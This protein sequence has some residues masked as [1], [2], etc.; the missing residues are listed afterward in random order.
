MELNANLVLIALAF[1]LT[2]EI[3]VAVIKRHSLSGTAV[4][5]AFTVY[6]A[7]LV[8]VTL[9]P[10][11]IRVHPEQSVMSYEVNIVPLVSIVQSVTAAD[12]SLALR[13]VALVV[14][15][16]IALFVPLGVLLPML[17]PRLSSPKKL[18]PVVL[19]FTLGIELLQL[20]IG[21]SAGY[22]Y[23]CVD[24]DDVVLNLTGGLIGFCLYKALLARG[25][26][27]RRTLCALS[28]D[29]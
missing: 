1:A 25:G 4:V 29:E 3:A 23:R 19:L 5:L 27:S 11:P 6:L 18:I 28:H 8:A 21:L 10:V 20:G 12:S 17:M 13:G 7:G 9:F 14:F 2:V 22:L 26:C 15:G 24:V 16:N